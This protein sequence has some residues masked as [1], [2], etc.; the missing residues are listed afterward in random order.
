VTLDEFT[1]ITLTVA[2]ESGIANYAPTIIAG[3]QVRVIQ[4]IPAGY[5]PRQAV[6]EVI[7]Q[8][9]LVNAEYY[10]GVKSGTQEITT[11]HH[12]EGATRFVRIVGLSQGYTIVPAETC[13]W[14]NLDGLGGTAGSDH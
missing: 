14:W 13:D 5:D 12:L 7:R 1:Q 9:G 11:G 10:F 8:E 3:E 2:S 6:Q 4:G